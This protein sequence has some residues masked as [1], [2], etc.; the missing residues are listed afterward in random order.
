MQVV[1]RVSLIHIIL[2]VG[3]LLTVALVWFAIA[4]CRNSLPFAQS[5]LHGL[6]L[7]LG[8]AI[9]SISFRDPSLQLLADFRS[10]DI[11]YFVVID[12]AGRIRFHTNPDLI[13]EP[14]EDQRWNMVFKA[15]DAT[16]QM[17]RLGTGET[18]F[19]S[20]QQL[21]LTGN[22]LVLRLALHTWQADQIV[23][24][25]KTTSA[26]IMALV[27]LAWGLG[28]VL[29]RLQRRALEH[30]Q[31]LARQEHLAQL[32]GL[33]AVVAH[34]VRTPLAGIKG[35]AQL[36][37]EGL[38]DPRQQRYAR[39]VVAE[40]ER[41]ELLVNE[42][43]TYAR[44]EPMPEGT[45]FVEQELRAV[46]EQLSAGGETAGVRLEVSGGL[47]VPVACDP[48]RIRQVLLNL[49]T[50]GVQ[51]MPD[52]GVIT[53]DLALEPETVALRIRDTGTGFPPEMLTR[54]FEPFVTTRARGSGLGLA[55][56]RKIVQGYLGEIQVKNRTDRQGG[57]VVVRLPL[58]KERS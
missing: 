42:L 34:E 39:T 27:V 46:W 3:S 33:G 38:N 54:V 47:N 10:N 22:T 57:E 41:L 17:I 7:S 56:C 2:T 20:Q 23:R 24:R 35:Y 45:A 30:R 29:L 21:H 4:N 6:A 50:N 9:E 14:I 48:D 16:R 28:A 11:A 12:P 49:L 32:G 37:E 8:Q 53:I 55:V 36:L 19:E 18:V 31:E 5:Y 44:Q 58:A 51:A 1:P 13:G 52:G 15:P 43:L 26:L 25:A 40:A